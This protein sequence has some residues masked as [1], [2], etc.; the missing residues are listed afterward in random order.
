[1]RILLCI[2]LLCGPLSLLLGCAST[3]TQQDLATMEA[4]PGE[5]PDAKYVKPKISFGAI[6][7]EGRTEQ[8]A[9]VMTPDFREP[10]LTDA[11]RE[12]LG[13]QELVYKPLLHDLPG[14]RPGSLSTDFHRAMTVYAWGSGG[15]TS[16]CSTNVYARYG[17]YGRGSQATGVSTIAHPRVGISAPSALYGTSP[18]D[19]QSVGTGLPAEKYTNDRGLG[20]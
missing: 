1:M 11:E 14:H 13:E 12:A 17:T 6:G 16:M 20:Y 15:A 4:H 10:E 7:V 3:P 8:P 5:L 18:R 19:G 9:I 2:T